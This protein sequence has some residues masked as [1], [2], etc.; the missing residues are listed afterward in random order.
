MRHGVYDRLSRDGIWDCWYLLSSCTSALE[1][2]RCRQILD[3]K[4]HDFVNSEHQWLSDFDRGVAFRIAS[5]QALSGYDQIVNASIRK[6][7]LQRRRFAEQE[8]AAT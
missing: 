8:Q 5:L 6:K 1:L 3:D 7:P 2:K 4:V